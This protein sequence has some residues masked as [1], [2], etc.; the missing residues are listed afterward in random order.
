MREK[1]RI[2][3]SEA[4]SLASEAFPLLV[5]V[6]DRLAVAGSI[7][8]GRPTVGDVELVAI[9]RTEQRPVDLFGRLETADLLDERCRELLADGTFALR[10]DKNG[11]HANGR[12]YKRLL[13]RGFPL[14][15]FVT[16]RACWG[17]VFLLRTGPSEFNQHLVLKRSLGGWL[18]RGFFFRDARVWRLPPPFDADLVDQAEPLATPEEADVFRV[19]GYAY[20]PPEQ[21]TGE[22]RPAAAVP[23]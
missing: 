14:D 13:F 18:P 1:S 4:R 16:D 11:H 10:L 22:R 8:R 20:V 15:L 5:D 3:L 6:C 7:R 21:R 2:P 19:L 12:K 23:A 17:V 9:A